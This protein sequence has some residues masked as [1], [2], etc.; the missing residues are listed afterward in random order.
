MGNKLGQCVGGN[1]VRTVILTNDYKKTDQPLNCMVD[2]QHF[3]KLAK[4][5]GCTD[6]TVSNNGTKIQAMKAIDKCASRCRAGETFVLFFA[7]HGQSVADEDGDE[8]DGFDEAIV[9][10]NPANGQITGDQI[11]IDDELASF[12]TDKFDPAV[13]ILI[14]TDCCHSGT[15][16]DLD[17]ACWEPFTAISLSA[18]QDYQTS[19]DTGKGGVLTGLICETL[20]DLAEASDVEKD[21]TV[22]AFFEAM[23]AS[24][25]YAQFSAKQQLSMMTTS[26]SAAEDM[27]WPYLPK[28]GYSVDIFD[29]PGGENLIDPS[30]F[31]QRG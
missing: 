10:E 6:L 12:L 20:E 18:C 23:M 7:G 5:T 15:I 31:V 14:I 11:L 4:L 9:F 19:T 17:K 22:G 24:E 27:L 16:G 21:L 1:G 30:L 28:K 29:G 3:A 8:A 13:K 2:S 25:H 26:E